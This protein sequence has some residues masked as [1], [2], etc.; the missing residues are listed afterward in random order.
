M[1]GRGGGGYGEISLISMLGDSS[2]SGWNAVFCKFAAVSG[3]L[4]GG[5][6]LGRFLGQKGNPGRHHIL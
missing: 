2:C 5:N 4:G 6:V 1:S 3:L